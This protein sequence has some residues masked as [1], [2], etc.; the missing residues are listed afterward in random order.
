MASPASSRRGH[1]PPGRTNHSEAGPNAL[2]DS[3]TLLMSNSEPA[4]GAQKQ[5]CGPSEHDPASFERFRRVCDAVEGWSHDTSPDD[6]K[7]ASDCLEYLARAGRRDAFRRLLVRRAPLLQAIAGQIKSTKSSTLDDRCLDVFSVV[8]LRHPASAVRS[9]PRSASCAI[10]TALASCI[11]SLH[12]KDEP[13]QLARVLE[14]LGTLVRGNT[15]AHRHAQGVQELCRSLVPMLTHSDTSVVLRALR[16]LAAVAINSSLEGTLFRQPNV[17][18]TFHLLFNLIASAAAPK[19]LSLAI[20]VLL[21]LMRSVRVL[22]CLEAYSEL[23][24]VLARVLA[25]VHRV[26]D[27]CSAAT[28][29]LIRALLRSVPLQDAIARSA[30][31]V[32]FWAAMR[33]HLSPGG[34]AARARGR[35]SAL[36]LLAEAAAPALRAG[37]HPGPFS[38]QIVNFLSSKDV[39]T[40]LHALATGKD[41]RAKKG[42]ASSA[43][44]DT[45]RRA[46]LAELVSFGDIGGNNCQCSRKD[47]GQNGS[48]DGKSVMGDVRNGRGPNM[49]EMDYQVR[50]HA[51]VLLE[52]MAHHPPFRSALLQNTH[53]AHFSSLAVG[54]IE[55][56][57]EL[58]LPLA[59]LVLRLCSDKSDA[60]SVVS[61]F[62][63]N[64]SLPEL[65][66]AALTRAELDPLLHAQGTRFMAILAARSL[67]P[68]RWWA[69]AT[70]VSSPPTVSAVPLEDLAGAFRCA[71][72]ERAGTLRRLTARAQSAET[73]R[74][75]LSSRVRALETGAGAD[76][77]LLRDQNQALSRRADESE[78]KATRAEALAERLQL[79]LVSA[80]RAARRGDDERAELSTALAS[81]HARWGMLE[82]Q[83]RRATAARAQGE[84]ERKALCSRAAD[85]ETAR[86]TAVDQ[87]ASA[88]AELHHRAVEAKTLSKQL[89]VLA[90][91]YEGR[92]ALR[93]K[94]ESEASSLRFDL[95]AREKELHRARAD[96]KRHAEEARGAIQA[97]QARFED[98]QAS[99]RAAKA[100]H[101]KKEA[102]MRQDYKKQM[103]ALVEKHD[104]KIAALSKDAETARADRDRLAA[105]T[106]AQEAELKEHAKLASMLARL[107]TQAKALGKSRRPLG[108]LTNAS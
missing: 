12:A 6:I 32:G 1:P 11:T 46:E 22:S 88:R 85:A 94:A 17:Q 29:H 42:R 63:Q 61:L 16:A 68:D 25:P 15:V 92:D 35:W 80:E 23:P 64:G 44:L 101:E 65:L 95:S 21:D 10:V 79:E 86:Q 8:I 89:M 69:T 31:S 87:L 39:V 55:R 36:G 74:D 70:P 30:K 14:L 106:K 3:L 33:A 53:V 5:Q 77:Q 48:D 9:V 56:G 96:A 45:M 50:S 47:D 28:L 58:S 102:K 2:T 52:I 73:D 18:R 81:S 37:S 49:T 108:D 59:G 91:A 105:A 60:E 97:L 98:A 26:D 67:F 27:P 4:S 82:T 71:S 78:A 54:A 7:N 99:A 19:D 100:D 62:A 84:R 76:A 38:R 51:I 93:R 34:G 75:R 103:R 24:R 72:Q 41:K 104:A 90:R 43:P 57:S 66:A 107:G 40:T 83:L 20:E 13:V